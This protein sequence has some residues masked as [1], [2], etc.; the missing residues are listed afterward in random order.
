MP[1]FGLGDSRNS[2]GH[3]LKLLMWSSFCFQSSK[4]FENKGLRD[5]TIELSV[6]AHLYTEYREIKKIKSGKKSSFQNPLEKINYTL[7]HKVLPPPK[8]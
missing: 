5:I 2:M 4:P 1:V 8:K 3:F 6:H 7:C